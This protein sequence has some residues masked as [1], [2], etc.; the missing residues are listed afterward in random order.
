LLILLAVSLLLNAVAA[1]YFLRK[2]PSGPAGP[3]AGQG[4]KTGA[5]VKKRA[6]PSPKAI[7]LSMLHLDSIPAGVRIRRAA[8]LN[9]LVEK[10]GYQS[11]L[12]M[13]QG[14]RKNTLDWVQCRVKVGVD[15]DRTLNAAYQMT[16]DEFFALNNDRFDL[17]FIDG[18]HHADQVE[19]DILNALQIL[20]SNGTIVLHDCNPTSE[21]W[22]L[23]PRPKNPTPWTGDVWKT[24]VKL[25]ATR[26]DLTMCVVDADFGC[27]VIRR[28]RQE[29]IVIPKKLTYAQLEQNRARWLNLV[30]VDDFLRKLKS[31]G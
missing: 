11:Y 2:A 1:L 6:S 20:T 21:E 29:T 23:V 31:E 27:G 28:G 24:W 18:L 10:Y 17:V 15:P 16:S 22:Q 3:S 9:T 25:R 7:S 8:I 19:R 26:S 12:E 14:E 30:S 4:P 13:G 5:K